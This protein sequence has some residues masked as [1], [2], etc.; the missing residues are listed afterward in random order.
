MVRSW[1]DESPGLVVAACSREM[2]TSLFSQ[3]M[4]HS[5]VSPT[6]GSCM[7]VNRFCRHKVKHTISATFNHCDLHFSLFS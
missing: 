7:T 3:V 6:L 1:R 5:K 2:R 4:V